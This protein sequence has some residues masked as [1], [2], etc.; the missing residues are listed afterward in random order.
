M[1]QEQLQAVAT[2]SVSILSFKD[3]SKEFEG[4]LKSFDGKGLPI[5]EFILK[6]AEQC[7][8]KA[9][10]TV[11]RERQMRSTQLGTAQEAIMNRERD[12]QANTKNKFNEYNQT[13]TKAVGS[14]TSQHLLLI[15]GP[16]RMLSLL[17]KRVAL[18]R[19]RPKS[20]VCSW[21]MFLAPVCRWR[22]TGPIPRTTFVLPVR[23]LMAA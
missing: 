8:K 18:R 1:T 6:N 15:S 5:S 3:L 9:E 21:V 2:Q 11:S 4:R 22:S 23:A 14:L 20:R 12:L 7:F 17:N 19:S 16:V 10:Q 13:Y